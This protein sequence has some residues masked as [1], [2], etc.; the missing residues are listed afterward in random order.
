MAGDRDLIIR[1]EHPLAA[2]RVA[3]LKPVVH[4]LSVDRV[5]APFEQG[6]RNARQIGRRAFSNAQF[7]LQHAVITARR[8]QPLHV[9]KHGGRL[10]E[11]HPNQPHFQ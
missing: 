10:R 8:A 2:P 11:A 7:K 3:R 9:I 5:L 4:D 6:R 1:L